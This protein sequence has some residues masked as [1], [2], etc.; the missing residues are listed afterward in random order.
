MRNYLNWYC[1]KMRRKLFELGTVLELVCEDECHLA[2]APYRLRDTK[3]VGF[4]LY[5]FR[6]IWLYA[7]DSFTCIFI[8]VPLACLFQ[9]SE[10]CIGSPRSIAV[11]GGEAPCGCCLWKWVPWQSRK[12]LLTAAAGGL[13]QVLAFPTG[14][15]SLLFCNWV[16]GVQIEDLY[17]EWSK[18]SCGHLSGLP[19]FLQWCREQE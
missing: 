6:F 2:S 13:L 8:L 3:Q 4:S 12:V 11:H 9:R 15:R 1:S 19:C 17:C 16:W 7:Y 10:E 14:S 5:I 18:S